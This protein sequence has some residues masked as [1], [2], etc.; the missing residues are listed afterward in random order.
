MHKKYFLIS[1]FCF[2]WLTLAVTV[3][4]IA[5]FSKGLVQ[6][7]AGG[8]SFFKLYFFIGWAGF[9]FLLLGLKPKLR[10]KIPDGYLITFIVLLQALNL[11][12]HLLFIHQYGLEFSAKT[13]A[14]AYNEV[15]SNSLVHTHTL[16]GI[17]IP[18]IRLPFILRLRL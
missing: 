12:S 11:L 4:D 17:V 13:L 5:F 2:I 16:K 6:F 10:K 9:S 1:F 3:F 18:I 15:S 14:V 7:F 8:R